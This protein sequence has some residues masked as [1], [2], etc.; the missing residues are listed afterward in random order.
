MSDLNCFAFTG[1]LAAAP[2][3]KYTAG[4]TAIWSARVAVGYGYGEHKGT[5]WITIKVLG[6]RA[7]ALGKWTLDKGQQ[8]HGCGE[9]QVREYDK[10]DGGKGTAVEV[11]VEQFG[12]TSSGERSQ[13]GGTER[14]KPAVRPDRYAPTEAPADDGFDDPIPFVRSDSIY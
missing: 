11:L 2:E 12:S 9:L 6:K 4:G 7:E 8:V 5:S 10:K 14:Q 3:T 13:G 1:R